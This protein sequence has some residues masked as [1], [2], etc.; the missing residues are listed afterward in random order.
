MARLI[1][2]LCLIIGQRLAHGRHSATLRRK[3]VAASSLRQA[4]VDPS[5]ST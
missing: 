1:S 5:L 3:F 2:A 4:Q